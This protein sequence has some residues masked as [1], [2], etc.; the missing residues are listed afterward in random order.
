MPAHASLRRAFPRREYFRGRSLGSAL[1]GL[2]ATLLLCGVLLALYLVADLLFSGGAVHASGDELAELLVLTGEAD[3]DEDGVVLIP[4][5]Y[6]MTEGDRGIAHAVWM[7]R[8]GVLGPGLAA[9][10]R[11]VPA[12]RSNLSALATLIGVAVLLGL[13]RSFCLSMARLAAARAAGGAVTRLRR[14]LHRQALRLGPSDLTEEGSREVLGLFTE[15]GEA[16]RQGLQD[17]IQRLGRYPIKIVV[18]TL[19]ALLVSPL[20]TLQIAL[21]LLACWWLLRRQAVGVKAARL[22]AGHRSDRA[23]RLLAEGLTKARV[24][25]GYGMEEFESDRFNTHLGRYQ[26]DLAAAN[27]KARLSRGL[28]RAALVV[29]G[30]V[31]LAILG[32]KVLNTGGSFTPAH[33]MLLLGIAGCLLRPL[34]ELAD[35]HRDRHSAAVAADRIYRYLNRVPEV[36][37]AVGAKFLQ[38]LS[39]TLDFEDV[40]YT[41][42]RGRKLL[43]G[44][45]AAIPAGS[46]TAIAAPDLLEAKA[47]VSLPPRFL[48]PQRGRVKYDGED[49][50]WVTLESLRAET[51][52]V[53]GGDPCFTGTVRENLTGGDPE[54]P[55]SKVIDAAKTAH[56]H[57]FV[58]RFPQGY[59]TVL[60]EFG[61][62]LTPGQLFRLGLAR[63]VLRDPAVLIVEEPTEGLDEDS[64]VQL[65]DTF[66]RVFPGRT[67]LLLPGRMTTLRRADRVILL[68]RGRVEAVG[69][70][71]ELVQKVPLYRHWEYVRFNH[72]RHE[73]APQPAGPQSGPGNG[74]PSA[75]T[76]TLAGTTA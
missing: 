72:F 26:S 41:D 62:T 28:A 66:A 60:G 11:G 1:W 24:V 4:E 30:A 67:V 50:A 18:L 15:D 48:E 27:R 39:R 68:H 6:R 49:I 21:P 7:N 51:V 61:E 47:L 63:A 52:Y 34:N 56:V 44:V 10:Y 36:G 75:G 70:R 57:N 9:L 43:D 42:P 14:A 71:E 3:R 38:P 53:G 40:H 59:E 46:V 54:V 2:A 22:V 58:Q 5:G 33:A 19:F 74:R 35:L 25:R 8:D 76:A 20:T 29:A 17:G 73:T 32:T 16:L 12:L 55:L 37:Q 13:L 23:L 45:S 65:D 69:P 31:V 64:K